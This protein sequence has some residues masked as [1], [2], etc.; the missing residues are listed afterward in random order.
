[1]D[2]RFVDWQ[3]IR[4]LSPITD[5]AYMMFASTDEQIRSDYYTGSLDLY[6][7][8]LDKNLTMMGCKLSECYPR[9][10]FEGQI[11][12]TMPFGLISSMMLLPIIL[13]EK[14][15]VPD[16]DI[17]PEDYDVNM[18]DA[19]LSKTCRERMNGIAKD[20]VSYGLI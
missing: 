17:S 16:M 6:Y 15:N 13:C 10:V 4:F 20:F 8:T 11:K 19:L 5:I 14:D 9:E 18:L 12:S 7:E 3:V 2:L 1:M